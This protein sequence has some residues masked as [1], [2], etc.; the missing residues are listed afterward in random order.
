MRARIIA[1]LLAASLLGTACGAFADVVRGNGKVKTEGRSL[2]S[3]SSVS[4]SGSGDL[5]IHKGSQRLEITA[6]SNVLPYITTEVTGGVLKIGFKPFTSI[7]KITKL[8]FDGCLGFRSGRAPY[9][10]F[11]SSARFGPGI[12]LLTISSNLWSGHV[13]DRRGSSRCSRI[14]KPT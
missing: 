14:G 13:T 2:P 12:G 5:R 7:T 6:D 4:L 1:A 10:L 3:F 9:T 8:V 11:R